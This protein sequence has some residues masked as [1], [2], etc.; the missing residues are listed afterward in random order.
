[1][2]L[3]DENDAYCLSDAKRVSHVTDCQVGCSGNLPH[4][5][6]SL[7]ESALAV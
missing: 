5:V 7:D 2:V 3:T 1:M 6:M 4:N